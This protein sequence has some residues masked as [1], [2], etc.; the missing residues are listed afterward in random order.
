VPVRTVT[1]PVRVPVTVR[2]TQPARQRALPSAARCH[3]GCTGASISPFHHS[4][5][6]ILAAH[7]HE[8]RED[9]AEGGFE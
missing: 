2:F 4:V 3:A 7:C 1:V 9:A 8:S 6:R 5:D